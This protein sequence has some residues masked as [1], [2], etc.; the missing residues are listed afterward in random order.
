MADYPPLKPAVQEFRRRWDDESSIPELPNDIGI[1]A[2]RKLMEKY[3]QIFN[4][5][6]DDVLILS[7]EFHALMGSGWA[8]EGVQRSCREAVDD[9]PNLDTVIE[10]VSRDADVF[11]REEL[12][13][14]GI[15]GFD[16]PPLRPSVAHY[17]HL[18]ALRDPLLR[19]KPPDFAYDVYSKIVEKHKDRFTTRAKGIVELS[20][21]IHAVSGSSW[22][23]NLAEAHRAFEDVPDWFDVVQSVSDDVEAELIELFRQLDIPF[24]A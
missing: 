13:K 12:A 9:I 2:F 14:L 20:A 17:R 3:R 11:M 18:A 7:P 19:K 10:A 22:E 1:Q 4:D 15:A 8:G 6:V 23:D 5:R 21:D 16:F 24:N